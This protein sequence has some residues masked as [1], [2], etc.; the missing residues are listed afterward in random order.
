MLASECAAPRRQGPVGSVG[1]GLPYSDSWQLVQSCAAAGPLVAVQCVA[2]S[3]VRRATASV[4]GLDDEDVE[5]A[6]GGAR[7]A[8]ARLHE[9]RKP[10]T[11]PT[12]AGSTAQ[13]E[14]APRRGERHCPFSRGRNHG[15]VC[16]KNHATTLRMVMTWEGCTRAHGTRE[17]TVVDTRSAGRERPELRR[18]TS[19]RSTA[20][21]RRACVVPPWIRRSARLQP[22]RP[23]PAHRVGGWGA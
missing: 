20:Q 16:R 19:R 5:Q 4:L 6:G 21:F 10:R 13:A 17:Y 3:Q 2:P 14:P 7:R 12:Q 18:A 22:G 9:W 15:T 1:S 11:L 8:A 23:Q